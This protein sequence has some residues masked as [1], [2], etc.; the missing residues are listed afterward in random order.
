MIL[1]GFEWRITRFSTQ[2]RVSVEKKS[3]RFKA[4]HSIRAAVARLG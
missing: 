1:S 2:N 4:A 3:D